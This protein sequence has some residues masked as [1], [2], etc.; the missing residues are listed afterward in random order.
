MGQQHLAAGAPGLAPPAPPQPQ[1]PGPHCAGA[2]PAVDAEAQ[3]GRP[4]AAAGAGCSG[5]GRKLGPLAA[6][7]SGWSTIWG[8]P[9]F[10]AIAGIWIVV[11]ADWEGAG[12]L[13]MQYLQLRLGYN[14]RDQASGLA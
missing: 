4:G 1:P 14:T 7:S 5:S 6:L 13:L 3:G 8:S 9:Y 2:G 12:E 11:S 10:R